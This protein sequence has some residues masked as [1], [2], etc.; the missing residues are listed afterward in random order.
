MLFSHIEKKASLTLSFCLPSSMCLSLKS[1]N[2][3]IGED[4]KKDK[5]CRVR[6]KILPWV[7]TFVVQINDGRDRSAV[8]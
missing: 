2:I 3:S 1:I 4:L 8:A 6:G 7:K 5:L